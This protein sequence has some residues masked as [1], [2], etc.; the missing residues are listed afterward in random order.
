[1]TLRVPQTKQSDQRTYRHAAHRQ[2]PLSYSMY[3]M[4]GDTQ[5]WG[6]K[7]GIPQIRVRTTNEVDIPRTVRRYDQSNQGDFYQFC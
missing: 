4:L 1:M 5:Q 3:G 2:T 7:K 6:E